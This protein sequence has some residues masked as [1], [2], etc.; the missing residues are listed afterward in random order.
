MPFSWTWPNCK[1][2]GLIW[3]QERDDV[4]LTCKRLK[5]SAHLDGAY[6]RAWVM[7][8]LGL[9]HAW[10]RRTRWR[11]FWDLLRRQVGHA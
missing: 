8:R 2:C 10:A 5:R 4:C 11:M 9:P 7:R 6:G 3:T 1:R